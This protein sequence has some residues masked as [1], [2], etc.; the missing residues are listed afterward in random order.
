MAFRADPGTLRQAEFLVDIT[1]TGAD[2][3][4]RIET[5]NL[6]NY[7]PILG[8]DIFKFQYKVTKCQIGHLA[9]PTSAQSR[10]V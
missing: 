9:P 1:T 8:C 3:T 7:D 5:V 10:E 6:V 4:A 2:L